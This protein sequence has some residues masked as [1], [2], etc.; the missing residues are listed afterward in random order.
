MEFSDE[1]VQ[2]VWEKARV[3]SDQDPAEWR[4][5]ECGA[6][7]RHDSYGSHTSE[8]AW[9]IENISPGGSDDLDNLR[10]FHRDNSLDRSTGEHYCRVKA[11]LEHL[12]ATASI[13]SPRNK[14]V[15]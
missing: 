1:I 2:S 9:K 10:P 3:V 15:G 8:F 11:D 5:D 14:T 4:K 6:W 13:D 7:I 12:P